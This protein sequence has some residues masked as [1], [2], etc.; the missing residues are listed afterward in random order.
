MALVYMYTSQSGKPQYIGKVSGHSFSSLEQRIIQ[1]KAEFGSE[2]DFWA[3]WYVEVPS[4]ADADALETILISQKHP[5]YN[6][7]KTSWGD[8]E[9]FHNIHP[10]WIAYEPVIRRSRNLHQDKTIGK[11]HRITLEF[12]SAIHEYIRIMARMKGQSIKQ[13]VEDVFQ[14][15]MET[16]K[17]SYSTAQ[18]LKSSL[19]VE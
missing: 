4:A 3:V 14:E 9:Y 17:A 16:N 6:S 11:P 1:H 12:T 7:A 13:F 18:K 5:P 2:A 15:H 8:S 19:G 10:T